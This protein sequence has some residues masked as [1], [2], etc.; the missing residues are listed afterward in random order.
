MPVTDDHGVVVAVI[1]V[2]TDIT[3]QTVAL[4]A[5]E[6]KEAE[7]RKILYSV[8][9]IIGYVDTECRYRFVNQA[10]KNWFDMTRE[11]LLG[12]SVEEVFGTAAFQRF[13]HWIEAALR[14]QSVTYEAELQFPKKGLTPV[15]VSYVPNFGL[16]GKVVGYYAVVTDMT[17]RLEHE[18]TLRKAKEQA[19]EGS[20]AKSAFLATMSHELRTPLNAILGFSDMILREMF[21]PVGDAHY[22]E[23]AGHIHE[24]GQ[25]LLELIDQVLE[26]ARHDANKS[27]AILAPVDLAQIITTVDGMMR[28]EVERAELT[29]AIIVQNELPF[30]LGDALQL[31]QVLI[32]LIANA[33]KF[34]LPGGRVEVRA[35]HDVQGQVT[36]RIKDSGI[37][38]AQEDMGKA[39][40]LFGQ[41]DNRLTRKYSGAGIGLPLVKALVESQGGSFAI[42]SNVGIGTEVT[43]GLKAANGAR[44]ATL[45][46]N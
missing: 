18:R 24:S 43:I 2:E 31:R 3:V 14:G 12:R 41:I 45:Q 40:E 30:V 20:R 6:A 22:T 27:A 7:L 10:Y 5:L 35:T 29:F 46:V 34:T 21:G 16:E 23:Y 33:L 4:E 42:E 32:N 38:I 13:A 39:L 44:A 8:P 11:E 37:G 1:G 19:E 25:H 17:P 28:G 36:V 15:S 9:V 26:I